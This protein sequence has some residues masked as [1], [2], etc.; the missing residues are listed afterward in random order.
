MP[1]GG[2][3]H[4]HPSGA[5]YAE[6]FITYAA[7]EGLCVV[8]ATMTL[9]PPTPPCDSGADRPAAASVL[10]D[11]QFYDALVDAWSMRN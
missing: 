2:D 5:E 10:A 11:Q 7:E 3:I 4:N 1:K 6:R 8:R 9:V